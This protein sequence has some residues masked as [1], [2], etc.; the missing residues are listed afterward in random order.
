MDKIKGFYRKYLHNYIGI[1][2]AT[3][4][5][6]NLFIETLARQSLFGGFL[7]LLESPVVFL[8]NALLIFASLSF[9]MLF[10]HKGFA[11]IMVS[12]LWVILGVVN[13]VILGNRMTPF[14]TYDIMEIKDGFALINT[15]FSVKQIV[16]FI[17]GAIALVLIV[18]FLYRKVPV[19]KEKIN[20]K[21]AVAAILLIC[22]IAS[23]GTLLAIKANIVDTHF[24]NLAYGYRDNGFVYCFLATWLAKGVDRS[25]GYS[26][27]SIQGIF[28]DDEL[29]TTVPGREI[30]GDGK[31]PNIIFLQLES[32]MD[33][34]TIEGM[35]FSKDPIPNFRRLMKE[36]S[37]GKL[38]VPSMG[39]GTAN[40]EFEAITGMR[41][42]FFGPGEYPYK[43]IIV[44]K[45]CESIPYDLKSMGYS[46]HAIHNYRA[47]FY[48][49]NE[50]FPNLGFDSFTSLEY[51]SNI[52]KTPKKWAKDYVLTNE[53][54][55]ALESSE[56]ED[57]IY[58]ISVQ[59]HGKYP[60]EE[61]LKEPEIR[62]L[63]APTQE[64]KWAWE[65]Y[66]NQVYEMDDFLNQ[67]LGRLENYDEEVIVVFYGDHLPA[68]DN[69]TEDYLKDGRNTYQTDYVIWSNFDI[70]HKH[71]DL[72]A[73]QL[74]PEVLDRVGI[75][76]GTFVTYH[77]NYKDSKTY[78]DD[79]KALQYDMLYGKRY[80]YKNIKPLAT[81]EMKMGVA[82]IK[83]D[84]VVQIG[85]KF[86]IKGQNFTEYSKINLDGKILDTVYLGPTILGLKEEVDPAEA[87]KMKVSQVEKGNKI[88]S[89]TE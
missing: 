34:M 13:G 1:C 32:F 81:T 80:I 88:L 29:A 71:E 42:K 18:I 57:Y 12:G 70:K 85:E 30:E 16:L 28:T 15:Y 51:M 67:L 21:R 24:P 61:V 35:S 43:S 58:A 17:L 75:H 46:T 5:L 33:P 83:I 62:V 20:Y 11:F 8:F 36:N 4:I 74:G 86:Y 78:R 3:A 63:N 77:Q 76:N 68:L 72:Y 26:Q 44:D 10:R 64:L 9:T 23:G 52:S 54:M 84:E 6:L 47:A 2:A 45:T 31:Q 89:T 66:V 53:I 49:R 19:N 50:V 82:D 40:T 87:S 14:T 41:T 73:Y 59:G 56:G 69:V 55:K 79:L 25:V 48:K 38:Q 37:S 65:Y 39:A 27:E 60:T 22:G 7:W